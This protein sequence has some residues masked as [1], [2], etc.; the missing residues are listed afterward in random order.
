M[1]YYNIYIRQYTQILAT[2]ISQLHY[3]EWLCFMSNSCTLN[4]LLYFSFKFTG[5][6]K[7]QIGDIWTNIGDSILLLY[8][9]QVLKGIDAFF[10]VNW[11]TMKDSNWVMANLIISKS[12]LLFNFVPLYFSVFTYILMVQFSKYRPF[13]RGTSSGSVRYNYHSKVVQSFSISL[14][15]V[16]FATRVWE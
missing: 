6:S 5:M 14:K 11:L 1:W 12:Y 13:V 10:L 8:L 3:G 15:Y 2:T 9:I 4:S 7:Q 16:S